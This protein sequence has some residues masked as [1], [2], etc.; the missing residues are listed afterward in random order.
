MNKLVAAAACLALFG[1]VR[2]EPGTYALDPSHTFVTYEIQHFGTSTSRGRFDKSEGSV[3]FDRAAKKGKV[4]LTVNVGSLKTG[5]PVLDKELLSPAFFNAEAFPTAKFVAEQFSFDGDK[6]TAVSGRLSLLGKTQDV[7]LKATHFNCYVNP[8]IKREAC[9]G[10]F[11]TTLQRSAW[12]LGNLPTSIAGES[13]RLLI[14][15]EGVQQ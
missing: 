12:G 6:V 11:E 3:V 5:V 1:A 8:F 13:V 9:G 4:E 14:Q 10:D 15:V 2:A 7:T